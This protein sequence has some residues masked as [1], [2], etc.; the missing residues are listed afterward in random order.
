MQQAGRSFIQAGSARR[1]ELFVLDVDGVM[2]TGQ[3]LYSEHGKM[4]KVFGPHDAD[5]LK[6]VR[7]KL[8]I[9]FITADER[10]FPISEKRIVKDMGF[11]LKLVKEE[12]RVAFFERTIGFES[13]IFMGDGYH[14]AVL[15]R[16]CLCG[17]APRNAR[18]E[19]RSAADYVTPSRAGEGAVLD[20]CLYITDRYFDHE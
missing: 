15:L 10:G 13:T 14:D 19:A 1:P 8:R 20:A 7:D 2:T 6:M 3:F 9:L 5:G 18:P 16:R 17:I 11:E 12:E 4:Y